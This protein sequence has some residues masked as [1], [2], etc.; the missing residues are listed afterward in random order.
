[1]NS[2]LIVLLIILVIV[3]LFGKTV[4]N[5]VFNLRNPYYIFNSTSVPLYICYKKDGNNVYSDL[6]PAKGGFILLTTDIITSGS[7]IVFSTSNINVISTT[8]YAI[9]TFTDVKNIEYEE[10]E[11]KYYDQNTFDTIDL[12]PGSNNSTITGISRSRIISNKKIINHVMILEPFIIK[13]YSTWTPTNI[14]VGGNDLNC[15]ILDGDIISRFVIYN[16]NNLINGFTSLSGNNN[17]QEFYTIY[18]LPP[19][20]STNIINYT[21]KYISNDESSITLSEIKIESNRI[22]YGTGPTFTSSNTDYLFTLPKI[23][24][25]TSMSITSSKID[26]KSL[27]IELSSTVA[28]RKIRYVDR[29]NNYT[30][31]ELEV[32]LYNFSSSLIDTNIIERSKVFPYYPK[33]VPYVLYNN[34]SGIIENDDNEL[35]GRYIYRYINSNNKDVYQISKDPLSEQDFVKLK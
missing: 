20:V 24:L 3:V 30:G 27:G 22:Y 31:M 15:I 28:E 18:Y 25:P 11:I 14:E 7:N 1:M 21:I 12:I 19:N 4:S 26:R 33:Q 34:I 9:T 29:V 5:F 6:I 10:P 8:P 35:I 17:V 13:D 2:N 16:E 32:V 23:T